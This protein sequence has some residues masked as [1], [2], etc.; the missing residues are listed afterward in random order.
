MSL[1]FQ[2]GDRLLVVAPHPDDESLA[3]GGL[4]QRASAAGAAVR[5]LFVTDGDNNPWPQRWVERRWTIGQRERLRWGTLRRSEAREALQ[6]L[7]L[8]GEPRFLSLPDQGITAKLLSADQE[9]LGRFCGELEDW[10]PTHVI[11]PSSYDIHPD[12][13]ALYVLWQIALERTGLANLPQLHFVIHG[14]KTDI[15]LHRLEL[16][17]T[18]HERQTKR[19]AIHCHGTQMVLSQKR[20]L[21]YARPLEYFYKAAPVLTTLSNHRVCEAF[22]SAGALHLTVTLPPRLGKKCALLIAAES[23]TA[24]S[25][26]WLVPLPSATGKV[27][28]RDTVTGQ[29]LRCATVRIAAGVA[30]VKIPIAA[31]RPLT[32]LFVKLRQRTFF[33]DEAGWREVPVGI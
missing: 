1:S 4:L 9:T 21:A 8:Q 14:R 22:L 11:L 31:L 6:R 26:R 23:G 32:Q 25:Q 18:E 27:P 17:L 12:H 13:N 15:I 28:M 30:R 7:G 33:L 16:A 19:Q 2:S 20:F 10:K 5:V 24:G 29:Q 3:T